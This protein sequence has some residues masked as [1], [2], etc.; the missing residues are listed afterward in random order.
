MEKELL[1]AIEFI[2]FFLKDLASTSILSLTFDDKLF[3]IIF[4]PKQDF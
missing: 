1:E 4:S 2:N 3:C